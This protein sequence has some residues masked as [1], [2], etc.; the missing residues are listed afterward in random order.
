MPSTAAILTVV[1][2]IF[3]VVLVALF[4]RARRSDLL[5]EIM[6]KRAGSKLVSKADYV[7]GVEEIPVVLALTDD[8]FYYENPDLQ[9]SFDLNR[10]DEI[11][12]T[13]DLMTGKH[14]RSGCRVLRLRSHGA[15]FEFLIDTPESKKWEAALR[16][17]R[18]DEPNEAAVV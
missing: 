8:T 6:K 13:D 11:E 3:L 10:I 14:I 17:H 1:G 16:P 4:L 9:A 12:Y 5:S 15:T 18:I 2:V 7:E